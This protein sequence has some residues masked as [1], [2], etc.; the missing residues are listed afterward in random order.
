MARRV[1]FKDVY[2]AIVTK[3]DFESYTAEAP[4]KLFKA[5]TG[6]IS[7][8]KSSE[9]IYSD[10][11]VED[12]LSALESIDVE[13]EGDGLLL[14]IKAAISGSKLI[15]GMLIENKD[16]AAVEI[17]LGFRA[18]NSKGKYQFVWLYCGKFD[19]DDE[20]EYETQGEKIAAQTKS[21]K[22]TF[23][24]RTIDG[25]Y[26][27]R[28]HEDELVTADTEA[29]EIIKTWFS[30]VPEPLKETPEVLKNKIEVI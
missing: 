12:I 3:N 8:K 16:D 27:V 28:V 4:Q 15:K 18:K 26:R 25:T 13:L 19:G 7:V 17:A 24:A 9:K 6:K 29:K 10:D 22:G 2:V 14:A 20:D 5:V 11:S 1:G 23:Y 21:L 30:S